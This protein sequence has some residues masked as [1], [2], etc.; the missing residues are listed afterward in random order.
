MIV[1]VMDLTALRYVLLDN[2]QA[3]QWGFAPHS[4]GV[5]KHAEL[6]FKGASYIYRSK[7]R[8]PDNLDEIKDAMKIPERIKI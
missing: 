6:R 1:L 7:Q 3:I 5:P 8:G 2:I 4:K